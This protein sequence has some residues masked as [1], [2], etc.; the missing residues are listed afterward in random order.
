MLWALIR[1]AR[2]ICC[3]YSLESPRRGDSNEYPQHMF[4][5]RTI[6]NY[7]LMIITGLLSTLEF[8]KQCNDREKAVCQFSSYH[9]LCSFEGIHLKIFTL[10]TDFP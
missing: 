10:A 5:W 9:F 2:N 1:I 8:L 7:P 4:L 3:G 6:E